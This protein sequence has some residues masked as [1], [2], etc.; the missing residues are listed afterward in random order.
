MAAIL[1]QNQIGEIE[2]TLRNILNYGLVDGTLCCSRLIQGIRVIL[3]LIIILFSGDGDELTQLK[4]HC[5][6]E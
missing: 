2:L 1:L 5:R 4:T 3:H 6:N